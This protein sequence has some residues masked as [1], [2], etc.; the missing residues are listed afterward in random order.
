MFDKLFSFLLRRFNALLL[1]VIVFSR[2]GYIPFSCI[3]DLS[4][5]NSITV[6]NNVRLGLTVV[7]QLILMLS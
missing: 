3:L 2:G 1:R 5:L 4:N 6:G 7:F